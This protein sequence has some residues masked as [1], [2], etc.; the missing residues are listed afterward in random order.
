MDLPK[1][2]LAQ[3]TLVDRPFHR[4]GWVFEEKLDGWRLLAFKSGD[5]VRLVSRPGRDHTRRFTDLAAAIRRLPQETLVLDGEVAIFDNQLV[6]RFEWMRHGKPPGVATPTMFMVFD[7]LYLEGADLRPRELRVRREAL[8]KVIDNQ[9]L[10]LPVRR[11]ADDGLKAWSEVEQRGY[12]GYVAK[13]E[14]SPYTAGQTLSWLKVKQA[15]Y[16]VIERGWYNTE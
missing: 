12:E 7:C 11:L 9:T 13:D 6:S 8:E 1:I 3:P 4:D 10:I 14:S 15:E 16:R 2:K 5:D